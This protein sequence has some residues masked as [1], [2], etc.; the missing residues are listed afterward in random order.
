MPLNGENKLPL[1]DLDSPSL[2]QDP[3]NEVALQDNHALQVQ[4]GSNLGAFRQKQDKCFVS[5]L[6]TR[7]F[8]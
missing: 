3:E 8:Y 1:T 5:H 4:N 7:N 6:H 2:S